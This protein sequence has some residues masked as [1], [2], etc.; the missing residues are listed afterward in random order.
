MNFNF[1]NAAWNLY[2]LDTHLF[3]DSIISFFQE[4]S[5]YLFGFDSR[6]S[7]NNLEIIPFL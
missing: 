7:Y 1:M 3:S 5:L 4:K 2:G 6:W